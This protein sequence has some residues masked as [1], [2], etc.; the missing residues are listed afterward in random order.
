MSV[1][2]VEVAGQLDHR[3]VRLGAAVAEERALQR[4]RLR[5]QLLGQPDLRLGHVQIRGVPDQPRLL[6]ERFTDAGIGVSD[7]DGGD[8]ADEV[9]VALAVRV[10]HPA[11]LAP[12]QRDRLRAVVL[13]QHRLGALH[14]ILVGHRASCRSRSVPAKYDTL[15]KASWAICSATKRA[16]SAEDPKTTMRVL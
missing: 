7:A 11:P 8:A 5:G 10:E 13:E 2:H 16:S 3:L 4:L 1:H 15:W 6:H 9:E 12:N 14:E